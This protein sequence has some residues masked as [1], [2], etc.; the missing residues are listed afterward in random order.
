MSNCGCGGA[1]KVLGPGTSICRCCGAVAE[2]PSLQ[3]TSDGKKLY[4]RLYS[5]EFHDER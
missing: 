1:L 3:L 5:T 4:Q 2:V